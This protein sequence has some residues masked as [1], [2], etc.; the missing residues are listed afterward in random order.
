MS[1][2]SEGALEQAYNDVMHTNSPDNITHVKLDMSKLSPI[3]SLSSTKS[4]NGSPHDSFKDS[5]PQQVAPPVYSSPEL[6]RTVLY[7]EQRFQEPSNGIFSPTSGN[8]S[9]PGNG[10]GSGTLSKEE[11]EQ[12][13]NKVRG[14]AASVDR[15]CIKPH[16][17]DHE[18]IIINKGDGQDGSGVSGGGVSVGGGVGDNVAIGSFSVERV[19]AKEMSSPERDARRRRLANLQ[20]DF[21]E[22]HRI[23]INASQEAQRKFKATQIA[24]LSSSSSSSSSSSLSLLLTSSLLSLFFLFLVEIEKFSLITGIP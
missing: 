12:M 6:S 9:G 3:P 19:G 13:A 4:T 1:N 7:P 24:S 8:K 20:G 18:A 10:G 16:T 17:L 21:E 14:L 22:E 11:S 5:N 15:G 2:L 23:I